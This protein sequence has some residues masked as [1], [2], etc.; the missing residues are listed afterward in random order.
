MR[1]K[2]EPLKLV[3]LI[4]AILSV[5]SFV[6]TAQCPPP[7]PQDP[8]CPQKVKVVTCKPPKP[9]KEH[10]KGVVIGRKGDVATVRIWTELDGNDIRDVVLDSDTKIETTTAFWAKHRNVTLVAPGMRVEVWGTKNDQTQLVARKITFDRHDMR[11]LEASGGAVAPLE[12]E[13]ALL[14][15]EQLRLAARQAELDALHAKLAGQQD[16]LQNSHQQLKGQVSQIQGEQD[17]MKLE[18]QRT[19][20]ETAMFGKRISELDDYETRD[21]AKINFAS[22]KANL[23]PEA[24]AALDEIATKALSTEGYLV[25]VVGFTDSKGD[26]GR[27]VDLSRRRA[28][29]VIDYL[30]R[31]KLVPIRRVLNPVGFGEAQ[32]IADNSSD[33]GRAENRRAEVKVLVNRALVKSQ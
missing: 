16:E 3:A 5:S 23:T 7:P 4:I 26:E 17:S 27:N 2:L 25:E 33:I 29:A 9:E 11:M 30:E 12:A 32:P 21:T 15:D 20:E 6:V 14:R 19:K 31:V 10:I 24:K 13:Q 8:C 1:N 22:G 28:E 18:I